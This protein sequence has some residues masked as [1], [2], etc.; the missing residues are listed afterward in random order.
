M[1]NP[2]S[3][4]I[5]GMVLIEDGNILS[6]KFNGTIGEK[7]LLNIYIDECEG[8]KIG[9]IIE[10]E[11]I[12]DTPQNIRKSLSKLKEKVASD[13]KKYTNT[14]S[15]RPSDG[16]ILQIDDGFLIDGSDVSAEEYE[17]L[18][19]LSDYSN[20]GELYNKCPLLDY[21]ITEALVSLR[22]KSAIKVISNIGSEQ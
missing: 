1:V 18:F 15:L 22:K 4:Q 21:Q 9:F 5:L 16:I 13:F 8:R 10:P 2:D 14:K 11:I 20:V 6:C 12:G 17:I 19:T 7:S 3:K